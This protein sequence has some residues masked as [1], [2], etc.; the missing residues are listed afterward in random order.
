MD[1]ISVIL[2]FL[3]V[4]NPG[5]KASPDMALKYDDQIQA[6]QQ[7]ENF[8]SYYRHQRKTI[9]NFDITEGD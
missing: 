4:L 5:E 8:D 3:G 2:I 9:V 1:L 7:S 6:V